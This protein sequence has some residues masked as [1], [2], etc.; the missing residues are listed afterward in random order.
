MSDCPKHCGQHACG[1]IRKTTEKATLTQI[2]EAVQ[3]RSYMLCRQA[4]R[5]RTKMLSMVVEAKKVQLSAGDSTEDVAAAEA[6]TQVAH[7]VTS[8]IK[9]S[10]FPHIHLCHFISVLIQYASTPHTVCKHFSHS[11]Q[12]FLIQYVSTPQ[13][14]TSKLW[15]TSV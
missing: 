13:G 12:A 2:F 10:F 11:M 15:T 1:F 14:K 3:Q 9:D 7:L 8:E 4:A 6:E 5:V